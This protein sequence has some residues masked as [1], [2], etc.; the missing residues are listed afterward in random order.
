MPRL[1]AGLGLVSRRRVGGGF[2]PSV[3]TALTWIW[4]PLPIYVT[5]DGSDKVSRVFDSSGAG[6]HT[7]V[8]T[9]AGRPTWVASG[10]SGRPSLSFD[11][12]ANLLLS[13]VMNLPQPSTVFVVYNRVG[14]QGTRFLFDALTSVGR[15]T[16]FALDAG[17][18]DHYW[19]DTVSA[20]QI[21]SAHVISTVGEIL[22][23]QYNGD[24]SKVRINGIGTNAA[25]ASGT[26]KVPS[27]MTLG[28]RIS[29]TL[30]YSG[31]V[32]VVVQYLASL[33]AGEI[34]Q[35][36]SELRARWPVY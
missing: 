19:E 13:P 1:G 27:G 26:P 23:C 33:S 14:A 11:G 28:A 8:Q 25:Y 20:R 5:K 10:I 2:Q 17:Q 30:L 9:G 3:R 32:S 35:V 31:L 34:T 18:C 16:Y 7:Q 22:C 12:T 24:S 6:N 36:E 4:E 21:I 29:G 15:Q